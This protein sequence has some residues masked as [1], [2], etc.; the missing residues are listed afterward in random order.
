MGSSSPVR[1]WVCPTCGRIETA[2]VGAQDVVRTCI[3]HK[4]PTG[5]QDL[6][7]LVPRYDLAGLR[8]RVDRSDN[9]WYPD[10]TV[11]ALVL[12]VHNATIAMGSFEGGPL[13]DRST[14]LP[15][16]PALTGLTL[17]GWQWVQAQ[18]QALAVLDFLIGGKNEH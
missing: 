8:E 14:G 12:A 18:R 15:Y 3:V 16:E 7:E 11:T 9:W 17:S 5:T 13:I 10:D 2:P 1:V 6:V 4:T